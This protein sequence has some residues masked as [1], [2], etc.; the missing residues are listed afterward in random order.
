MLQ[1]RALTHLAQTGVCSYDLGGF[2]D[3]KARWGDEGLQTV[4]LVLRPRSNA[5]TSA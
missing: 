4:G 3:Y 2:S 1:Y 5:G